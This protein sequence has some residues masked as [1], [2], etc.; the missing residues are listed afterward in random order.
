MIG[1][2]AG[3]SLELLFFSRKRYSAWTLSLI[4]LMTKHMHSVITELKLIRRSTTHGKPI[5]HTFHY[6][7]KA[8]LPDGESRRDGEF[9]GAMD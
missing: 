7:G 2:F 6:L 8:N 1:G 9:A 5:L 4:F 3:L